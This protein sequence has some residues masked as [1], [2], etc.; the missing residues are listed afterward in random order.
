MMCGAV[1]IDLSKAFDT[2]DH[3]IILTK[4]TA[5]GVCQG[6]LARFKSYLQSR[7]L[8]TSVGSE[9]SEPLSCNIGVPQGSVLGPLLFI[10]YINDPILLSIPN[11][12]S[13]LMTRLYIG[14]RNHHWT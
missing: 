14:F 4:L 5:V 11:C 10:I 3:D 7:S 2:V 9:L 6:D 13:L 1:F 8:Q 12:P